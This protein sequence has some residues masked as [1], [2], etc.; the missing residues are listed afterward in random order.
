MKQ[1]WN[2]RD[3]SCRKFSARTQASYEVAV[4]IA[5]QKNSHDSHIGDTLVKLIVEKSKATACKK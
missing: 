1:V 4:E 2:V 5:K 3:L